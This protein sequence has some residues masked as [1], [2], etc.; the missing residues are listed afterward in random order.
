M[1]S[2]TYKATGSNR[3]SSASL[4]YDPTTGTWV[5]SSP[6]N[7]SS[8]ATDN[9]SK[10]S[11]VS[12]TKTT[13][14]TTTRVVNSNPTSKVDSKK[15]ADKEYIEVEFN[16]LTG[17]L[18]L[19]STEKSI[20]IKVN[21][22]VKIEGLGKN[23]SG[24]YFVSSIRRTLSKDSGYTHTLSL[25]KNG[26]GNSLKKSQTV[27]DTRK[28]Q[29]SKTSS[30]LKVGDSVK[31]VGAN[32]VYSNAHD[33]VKVPAWVKKKTLK[34]DAISKDGTRVRLMPIWSWTYVKYVQ[35]V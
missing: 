4:V 21:D 9:S 8:Q 32:A 35:K 34:V 1:A 19:T 14:T 7:S 15:A 6:A 27:T 24:L 5:A 20:R 3:G 16:T 26:F 18:T 22:T 30:K 33:G 28:Q 31:I 23:L 12:T 11:N 17:D 10:N 13:T 29:V 25:I 2:D